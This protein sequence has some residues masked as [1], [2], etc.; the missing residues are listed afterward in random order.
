MLF[1]VS[2]FHSLSSVKE[3]III[4][5]HPTSTEGRKA[6]LHWG[7]NVAYSE[8]ICNMFSCNDR[9]ALLEMFCDRIYVP[10]RTGASLT[11]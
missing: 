9:N 10:Q 7:R 3:G 11:G 1:L 2:P 8:G 5:L 6:V 4:D